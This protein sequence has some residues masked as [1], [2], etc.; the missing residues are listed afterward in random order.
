M[1]AVY[2]TLT[3][4]VGVGGGHVHL[5]EGDEYDTADAVVQA[6]P[7]MFTSTTPD[8]DVEP[9]VAKPRRGRRPANG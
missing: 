6:H 7:H 2:A 9:V 5:V 4:F 3:A 1:S 8:A